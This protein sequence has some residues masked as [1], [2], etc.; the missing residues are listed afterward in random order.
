MTSEAQ[1]AKPSRRNAYLD[2]ARGTAIFGVVCIHFGGSFATPAHAWTLSFHLGLFLNQAFTFAVPVFVFISGLLAGVAAERSTAPLRE[3]YKRRFLR[4]A[5]PY[6]IVSVVSFFLLNHVSQWRALATG[7]AQVW[8]WV[9]RLAYSGVEPTLYFIPM[10]LVL[11]ILQPLLR[12]LPPFVSRTTGLSE[13][14]VTYFLTGTFF[15]LHLTLAYLCHRGVLSYY[16]WARPCPLFWLFYFFSGLHFRVLTEGMSSATLIKI[17]GGACTIA[18][19]ALALDFRQLYDVTLVGEH[20]ERNTVD[21]AYVRPVLLTYD[22]A[23]CTIIAAG[24]RLAWP[25][26]SRAI[27]LLGRRSLEIYLWHIILL[28]EIAWRFSP[29][30]EWCR[31]LPELIILVSFGV[32]VLI[33]IIWELCS[34]LLLQIRQYR[35]VLVKEPW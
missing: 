5:V 32:C 1:T 35:V 26:K 28:F 16:I 18:I 13:S 9:E 24:Y 17:V 22:L 33:A 21:H 27:E 2:F 11:Y 14:N 20:F 6:L 19:G 4:I 8:W 15:I 31:Q 30:L 3:Y 25:L 29:A 34:A 12:G 7:R 10:I 23:V